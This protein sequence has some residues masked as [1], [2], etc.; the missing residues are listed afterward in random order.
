MNWQPDALQ[1]ENNQDEERQKINIT[2]KTQGQGRSLIKPRRGVTEV[3]ETHSGCFPFK[4]DLVPFPWRCVL[5][6]AELIRIN[7]AEYSRPPTGVWQ[8]RN[9]RRTY[10]V[11]D[12]SGKAVDRNQQKRNKASKHLTWVKMRL[13]WTQARRQTRTQ[14]E[15]GITFIFVDQ[16]NLELPHSHS[17]EVHQICRFLSTSSKVSPIQ[18]LL[19]W[20]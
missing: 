19:S 2:V 10:D 3:N 8:V 13:S 6:D 20:L 5:V 14:T 18:P 17:S 16:R 15:A 11:Q 1:T 7:R 4:S 12:E 9:E